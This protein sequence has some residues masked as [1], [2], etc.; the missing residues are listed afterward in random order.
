MMHS[1][2]SVLDPQGSPRSSFPPLPS[3]PEVRPPHPTSGSREMVPGRKATAGSFAVEPGRPV[4]LDLSEGDAVVF[5]RSAALV[6]VPGRMQELIDPLCAVWCR[7]GYT[8]HWSSFAGERTRLDWFTPAALSAVLD[9]HVPGR[10]E[11]HDEL[12]YRIYYASPGLFLTQHLA[13]DSRPAP[14]PPRLGAEALEFRPMELSASAWSRLFS[15]ARGGAHELVRAVRK[16]LSLS[17]RSFVSVPEV[18]RRVGYSSAHVSRI[19]K[20]NTGLSILAYCHELRMRAALGLLEAGELDLAELA[21][22]LGYATHS[23]FTGRFKRTFGI[24]PSRY[25][26]LSEAPRS[27]R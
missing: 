23:H 18:A 8:L 26:R 5:G 12:P 24:T 27:S 13:V 7:A 17:Y 1:A 15:P 21:L 9:S 14:A 16:E 20:R 2:V 25:Q 11:R 22:E 19:F 3:G 6:D 10:G 4:R